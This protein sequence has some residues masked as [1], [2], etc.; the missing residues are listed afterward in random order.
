MKAELPDNEEVRLEALRRYDILDTLPEKAYEDVTLLA[1]LVCD[2]PIAL[3][4]LVD[5]DRQWFKSHLGLGVT[6]TPR[7]LSFCAHAILQPESLFLVPDARL[8]ARFSNNSLVTSAPH[9]QFY[10]GAPLVTSQ[11][12][13]LG[14][15]CV[16]D[17]APRDL[18]PRQQEALHALSRQVM[19][20]MEF[21]RQSRTDTLT[22]VR[23]RRAFDDILN[24][25][26]ER[27][28]R[29]GQAMS[30]LLLD[31]D[32]FKLFNDNFGHRAG[33]ELLHNLAQTLQK[34]ARATDCVARYGGE[35]FVVILPNTGNAGA[36]AMAE[37]FR[38]E[39]EKMN[40]FQRPV[41]ASIGAVTMDCVD[42]DDWHQMPFDDTD[43]LEAADKALYRAKANGRNQV[44]CHNL[45]CA[46]A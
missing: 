42:P 7:E 18:A 16:I 40:V 3:V 31:V 11:G 1:S 6:Q 44:V 30:L 35:E 9:I 27:A 39:I 37:R 8:D 28:K 13:P 14:T 38:R 19:M 36:C 29:Y 20:Q 33:D 17:R 4:S 26:V 45:L 23:N 46:T 25:E 12:Q 21:H 2:T 5:Q 43:L 10:A 15:I 41:T 32:F 34:S 24:T 22:Q